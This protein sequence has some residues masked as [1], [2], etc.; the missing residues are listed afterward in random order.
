MSTSPPRECGRC[1]ACCTAVA[2]LELNKAPGQPCP[3]LRAGRPGCGVYADRPSSCCTFKCG[4]L[5]GFGTDNDRPDRS[6]IVFHEH[7]VGG[8]TPY[9]IASEMVAGAARRPW[10]ASVIKT[11]REAGRPVLLLAPGGPTGVLLPPVG[12]I[13]A[14]ADIL[15]DMNVTAKPAD[16]KAPI[17]ELLADAELGEL[18]DAVGKPKSNADEADWMNG[19]MSRWMFR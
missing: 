7:Q 18:L 10:A 16:P 5:L 17:P 9:V 8:G 13:R 14:T 15:R 2:V 12:D 19:H 1:T 6:G 4:W 11:A 3:K